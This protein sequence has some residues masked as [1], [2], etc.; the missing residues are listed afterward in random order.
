MRMIEIKAA[1]AGPWEEWLMRRS[2][3]IPSSAAWPTIVALVALATPALA[4]YGGGPTLTQDDITRMHAAIGSL[5][6]GRP[7]G[8]VERWRSESSKDAGEVSLIR[9]FTAHGM[10]CNTIRYIVWFHSQ[11]LSP[12][13]F[14]LDW[15]R[16]GDG[17][18]KIVDMEG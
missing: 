15:C 5:N 11:P 1:Q 9:S 3:R 2:S 6:E 16:L 8:T 13:V 4:A 14:V 10:P 17:V 12:S 18:W 7:I